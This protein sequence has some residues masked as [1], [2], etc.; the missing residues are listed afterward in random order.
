VVDSERVVVDSGRVVVDSER[1]ALGRH[2]TGAKA[3]LE[4]SAGQ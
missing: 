4:P 2:P 3:E 1:L